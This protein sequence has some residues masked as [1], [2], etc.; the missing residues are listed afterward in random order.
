MQ[1]QQLQASNAAWRSRSLVP[2]ILL[3]ASSSTGFRCSRSRDTGASDLSAASAGAARKV[4]GQLRSCRA[5]THFPALLKIPRRV[6]HA[7]EHFP[8]PA[9][10]P[11]IQTTRNGRR[12]SALLT[13]QLPQRPA[14]PC[15]A[16]HCTG[17]PRP[18]SLGQPGVGGVEGASTSTSIL[19]KRRGKHEMTSS[20]TPPQL[21]LIADERLGEPITNFCHVPCCF[22]SLLS[23]QTNNSIS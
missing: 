9:S 22:T 18:A 7:H 10:C 20:P 19:S 21:H 23:K 5:N 17:F 6:P 4:Q 2:R 3:M 16:L 11:S 1:V 13:D 15:I 14:W 8:K 12:S